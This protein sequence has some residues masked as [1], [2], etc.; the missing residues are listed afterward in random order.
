MPRCSGLLQEV[1][2][3]IVP[4]EWRWQE[5]EVLKGDLNAL[6]QCLWQFAFDFSSVLSCDPERRVAFGMKQP[7][8][9]GGIVP[10]QEFVSVVSNS[11]GGRR[12]LLDLLSSPLQQAEPARLPSFLFKGL[13]ITIASAVPSLIPTICL[14]LGEEKG[15]QNVT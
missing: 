15:T 5:P 9:G 1:V 12:L 11:L 10:P 3:I 14:S 6:V 13:T 4:R 7:M 2:V 8:H